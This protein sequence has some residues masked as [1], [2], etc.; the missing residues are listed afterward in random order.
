MT[1]TGTKG[2]ILAGGSGTRLY[3]MTALYS[4]QLVT[5]YDK[6]MIYYP[7][8]TLMMA[9]IKDVLII[10][11]RATR[12]LYEQLF[13]DGRHLGMSI[14]YA[15]QDAPNG[16]AEAFIIGETFIGDGE[17]VLILGDNLF[18][19]YLDFLRTA[20]ATNDGATIFGYYVKNPERYGVVTFDAGGQP[21]SV[22]EKPAHPKS[23]YAVVGIYVFDS[24]V[25]EVAR[26]VAPSH[27]GE[28]EITSVIQAYLEARRLRV[29]R[30]GRGVAWLDSGTP[31]SLQ[32]ASSFIAT[33]E[34]RQGLKIGCIEE[35]AL[36]RG[37]IDFNQF[38]RLVTALPRCQYRD[39][40]G[41]VEKE[42][43]AS[44]GAGR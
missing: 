30:I 37:F 4:K 26:G 24:R 41:I 14:S 43:A 40:L 17:V 10:S 16:I 1:G 12:P 31:K 7:L 27:R 3:P 5:V 32:E 22:E 35:I 29:M 28:L 11:D 19:G 8:S 18:Y 15:V 42:L 38:K 2:I 9:D 6:P 20:V 36:R 33:I 39:Y 13:R 21:E 25:A 44:P 34:E 23:N